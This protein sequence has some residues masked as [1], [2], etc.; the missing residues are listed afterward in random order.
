MLH[1]FIS[2]YENCTCLILKK[3]HLLLLNLFETR[4]CIILIHFAQAR[5]IVSSSISYSPPPNRSTQRL[6]EIFT[7]R[8]RSLGQGNIFISVCQ[9]FCSQGGSTW[10]GTPPGRHTPPLG[11][12]PRQTS[13]GQTP[14]WQTPPRQ[15]PPWADTPRD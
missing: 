12:P 9:E 1:S 11:K 8:K 14:P 5:I 6:V 3:T 4:N 7:A 13:P 15:T 10:A 2:W